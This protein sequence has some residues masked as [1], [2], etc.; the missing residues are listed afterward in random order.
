VVDLALL[1]GLGLFFFLGVL[2]GP[3]RRLLGIAAMML[4][5]LVAGN[6]RAPAGDFLADNWT[7]F[8]KGYNHLLAFLIIFVVVTVALSI[9]IQGFYRRTDISGQ[10]PIVDDIVGGMLGLLQGMV[11]LLIVTIILN[12]YILPPARPGDLTYL[13]DAQNMIVNQS[14]LAGGLRDVIAGPFLH[15]LSFILPSDLVSRYP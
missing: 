14:H 9:T 2:Q 11:L 10:H 1:I 6:L 12:S 15:I 8:D 4:A 3:I 13:R 5:F 7:Q